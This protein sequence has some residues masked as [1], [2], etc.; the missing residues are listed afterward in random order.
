M[1]PQGNVYFLADYDYVG[2]GFD[3]LHP[4]RRGSEIGLVDIG[5]NERF[6]KPATS[7]YEGGHTGIWISKDEDR[8][9]SIFDSSGDLICGRRFESVMRFSEGIAVAI[10]N[11]KDKEELINTSGETILDLPFDDVGIHF[12]QTRLRVGDNGKYGFIDPEGSIAIEIAYDDASYSFSRDREIWVAHADRG[13]MI[14]DPDGHQKHLAPECEF[15]GLA[16]CD[17]RTFRRGAK[18]GYLTESGE[19]AV[20]AF[21]DS[22]SDFESNAGMVTIGGCNGLVDPHGD[23]VI[24][25]RKG[26][27]LLHHRNGLTTFEDRETGR[28]GVLD[29][30]GNCVVEP[31]FDWIH[32]RYP[33]V[34]HIFDDEGCPIYYDSHGNNIDPKI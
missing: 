1:S 13:R 27:N 19:E 2:E 25:P 34:I 18:W 5:G 23:W 22:T 17:R 10:E 21:Y 24:R 31:N 29:M 14:L 8:K 30:A 3:G 11:G 4:F 26:R 32:L 9:Y 28:V 16:C 15:V 7:I 6:R 20:P 12:A 33:D